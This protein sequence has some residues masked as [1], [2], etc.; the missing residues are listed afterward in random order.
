MHKQETA[1]KRLRLHSPLFGDTQMQLHI[2]VLEGMGKRE[3]AFDLALWEARCSFNGVSFNYKD[4]FQ[5]LELLQGSC[6]LLG[7]PD[8][9]SS[10]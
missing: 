9:K 1:A 4:V 2:H 6:M 8:S 7:F 5:F 3:A 10:K